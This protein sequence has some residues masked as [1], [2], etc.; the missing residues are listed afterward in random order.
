MAIVNAYMEFL[1]WNPKHEYPEVMSVDHERMQSLAAKAFRL[2]C[3]ASVMETTTTVS[4]VR[5]RI[6]TCSSFI[7]GISMLFE[8]ISTIEQVLSI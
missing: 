4:I 5:Q 3:I 7:R 1:D 8:N 6:E 2:C